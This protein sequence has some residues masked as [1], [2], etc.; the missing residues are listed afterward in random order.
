M[1]LEVAN[2]RGESLG[3]LL[4]SASVLDS[5][6]SLARQSLDFSDLGFTNSDQVLSTQ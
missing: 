4:N 2:E 6:L 1:K 3:P 5:V